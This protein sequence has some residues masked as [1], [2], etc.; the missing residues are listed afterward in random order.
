MYD[1]FFIFKAQDL[2]V[3]Q[4]KVIDNK[5]NQLLQQLKTVKEKL[6][7]AQGKLSKYILLIILSVMKKF[8]VR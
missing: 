3:L 5:A 1:P 7:I 4:A 6:T 8:N 2:L